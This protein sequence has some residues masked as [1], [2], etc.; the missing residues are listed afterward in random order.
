MSYAF[1]KDI[2]YRFYP[3]LDNADMSIASSVTSQTPA[4]YVFDETVPTRSDALSGANSIQTISSW[5]WNATKKYW[6]FTIAAIDDPHPD[7]NIFTRIYW[8]SINFILQSDEQT[9]TLIKPLQLERVVGHDRTV[10]VTEADLQ[11]YFP[12][13]VAY[14]SDVQRNAYIRQAIEEVK[15]T[16][17]AKGYDWAKI[18][19]AD[20]LDMCV[21]YKALSMILLSQVQ[22]PNDKFFIKYQEFKNSFNLNLDSL[23]LEYQAMEAGELREVETSTPILIMR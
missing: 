12:Q 22:E 11:V 10:S 6:S 4:I 16:L 7:S 13:V 2:T 17:K 8:I 14:S 3:L 1:G 21:T 15:A 23:R 20:R 19:R 18:Q 5:S 9:Q